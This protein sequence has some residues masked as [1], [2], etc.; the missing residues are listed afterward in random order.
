MSEPLS[1]AFHS[2]L[3]SYTCSLVL[4]ITHVLVCLLSNR[5]EVRVLAGSP[6]YRIEITKAYSAI[7]TDFSNLIVLNIV[8]FCAFALDSIRQ[9]IRKLN[10]I[11]F[12]R[13][14]EIL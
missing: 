6:S 9:L 3:P 10:P 7:L 13:A 2:A 8:S 12:G 1:T 11:A 4:V 5:S 14:H